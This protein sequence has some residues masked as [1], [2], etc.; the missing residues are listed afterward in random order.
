VSV[1]FAAPTSG[2]WLAV[3]TTT[4]NVTLP[5]VNARASVDAE[6]PSLFVMRTCGMLPCRT[7]L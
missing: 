1:Q 6:L 5:V 2:A 4:S 7:T 3:F